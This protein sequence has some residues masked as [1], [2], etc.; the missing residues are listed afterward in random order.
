MGSS[1]DEMRLSLLACLIQVA[2]INTC[3]SGV[4]LVSNHV[5]RASNPIQTISSSHLVSICVTENIKNCSEP[6]NSSPPDCR[7][8]LV[9]TRGLH[10]CDRASNSRNWLKLNFLQMSNSRTRLKLNPLQ[11][12]CCALS[13]VPPA[14]HLSGGEFHIL[15]RIKIRRTLW[16]DNWLALKILF[17]RRPLTTFVKGTQQGW[18]VFLTGAGYSM[19]GEI[20]RISCLSSNIQAVTAFTPWCLLLQSH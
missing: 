12:R 6:G 5:C 9:E 19:T 17:G 8:G 4:S 18:K 7:T 15:L 1:H 11:V 16:Y 13:S 14:L 3:S 20:F 2:W 10:F